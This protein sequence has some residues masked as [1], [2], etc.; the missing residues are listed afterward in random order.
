MAVD[1]IENVIEV[2][3]SLEDGR[4]KRVEFIKANA[5]IGGCLGGPWRQKTRLMRKPECKG[6]CAAHTSPQ[7]RHIL[8]GMRHQLLCTKTGGA[9]ES[10]CIWMRTWRKLWRR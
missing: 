7:L 4:I 3:D 9:G 8:D 1:G 10:L 5:C 6:S 2:L